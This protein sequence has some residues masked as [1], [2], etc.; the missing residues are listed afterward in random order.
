MANLQ[1]T[2][3]ETDP[4]ESLAE[5]IIKQANLADLPEGDKK[6][7]RENLLL[8]LNRRLGLIIMENLNDE[9]QREYGEL[10]DD[11]L[12]PDPKKL[13]DLLVKYITD[14]QEKITAGLKEFAK[15]IIASL[16]KK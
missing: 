3:T 15:Q 1:K 9:G 12:V 7:L 6:Y 2:I 10:L 16:V 14:Y 11:G 13:Q 4:L 8:Q 5:E